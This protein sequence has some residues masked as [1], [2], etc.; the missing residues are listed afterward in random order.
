[1]NKIN[2]DALDS[3]MEN[4]TAWMEKL[5]K[6]VCGITTRMEGEGYHPGGMVERVNELAKE[7]DD[8]RRQYDFKCSVCG[9]EWR[10]HFNYCANCHGY[11]GVN[12]E[13]ETDK[14]PNGIYPKEWYQTKDNWL[15]DEEPLVPMPTTTI[16]HG[17]DIPCQK[18]VDRLKAEIE[19]LKESHDIEIHQ[20]EQAIDEDRGTI[21]ELKAELKTCSAQRDGLC[22]DL[23]QLTSD[24][25]TMKEKYEGALARAQDEVDV[26]K[27]ENE[28]LEH[29][30]E[31][32]NKNYSAAIVRAVEAED[33]L[34]DLKGEYDR[35]KHAMACPYCKS[36]R[37]DR[38]AELEDEVDTLKMSLDFTASE[39]DKAQETNRELR[40][41]RQSGNLSGNFA[42]TEVE[43]D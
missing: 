7:V 11:T 23:A 33:T 4:I 29:M 37:G 32:V 6:T 41:M 12:F 8:M 2:V 26:F 1:M 16:Y 24:K 42:G 28:R 18:E 3:W 25:N 30:L 27:D 19:R 38:I 14:E 17:M 40:K 20:L 10:G 9:L 35:Q 5:E 22:D 21:K 31:T 39:R 13:A 15:P 34:T 36:G 43:D